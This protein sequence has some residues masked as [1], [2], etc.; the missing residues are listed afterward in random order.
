MRLAGARSAAPEWPPRKS[1]GGELFQKRPLFGN[2]KVAPVSHP[3]L[4]TNSDRDVDMID[5][6]PSMLID[7]SSPQNTDARTAK[8]VQELPATHKTKNS[9]NPLS[10]LALSS[11][12]RGTHSL[13]ILGSLNL[14]PRFFIAH[15]ISQDVTG[16]RKSKILARL[17]GKR[18]EHK[19]KVAKHKL[20]A[21]QWTFRDYENAYNLHHEVLSAP[22]LEVNVYHR[23]GA[24]LNPS[25]DSLTEEQVSEFSFPSSCCMFCRT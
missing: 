10:L 2:N 5:I 3:N 1:F 11:K 18:L 16:D 19:S 7:S 17:V 24:P 23:D 15:T 21:G 25:A 6:G 14:K 8:Q 12:P 13:G 22:D 9:T 4:S 20:R